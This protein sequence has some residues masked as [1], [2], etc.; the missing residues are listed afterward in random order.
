MIK[1][2]LKKMENRKKEI[3]EQIEECENR[4]KRSEY[5]LVNSIIQNKPVVSEDVKY[6]NQYTSQIEIYREELRE[7]TEAFEELKGNTK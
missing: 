1:Y 4:R 3:L 6:F 2:K 5:G 7:L